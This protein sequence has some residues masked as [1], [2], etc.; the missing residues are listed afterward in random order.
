MGYERG[1]KLVGQVY[2]YRFM[3]GGRLLRGSTGCASLADAQRW[4]RRY[5]A[6]LE[7]EGLGIREAPVL[8]D[9]LGEWAEVALATNQPA[10]I[11]R[12][13]AAIRKH[14]ADLLPLRI[15]QLTTDRVQAC[16]LAYLQ[17]SGD[18]PGRCGH[19]TGGANALLLR[20]NTLMGWALR[21]GYMSRKPYEVRRFK[22]QQQ[23]R[24][25][26]RA[27]KASEFLAALERIARSTHR[28]LAVALQFGL[29]VRESEAL[30]MRWEYIDLAH[31]SLVVGRLDGAAFKT[32]GGEARQIPIPRWLL[33]R[34][35]AHWEAS[36][37]PESGLVLPGPKNQITREPEPHSAGYTRALVRRIGAELGIPGLTPHRLRASFISSLVLEAGVSIPQVQKIV[38]HK[39]IATT[40][41]YVDGAD[42][43][44]DA[45][46]ALIELQGLS[47]IE[48]V[49]KI[50]NSNKKSSANKRKRST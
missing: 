48:H 8:E 22:R 36:R 25:V 34:L 47:S 26:V 28:R 9:L 17:G 35:A 2:H 45:F 44:V 41:R 32:K 50:E 4:L 11:D 5:Q 23:P 18:G 1:L 6:K 33:V 15:D 43:H 19:T 40:M 31:G 10:E 29:G 30:G 14:F 3:L 24:P 49:P 42:E 7:L 27:K 13:K 21:C 20:L 46:A 38:G 12:M 39:H 16:L 37:K